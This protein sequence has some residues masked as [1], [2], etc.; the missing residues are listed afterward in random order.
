MAHTPHTF[1]PPAPLLLPVSLL[2]LLLP[3]L[4]LAL[5]AAPL[6]ICCLLFSALRSIRFPLLPL[7]FQLPVQPLPP[8]LLPALVTLEAVTRAVMSWQ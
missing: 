5:L 2:L 3:P 6:L 7:C 1:T 4:L 8:L